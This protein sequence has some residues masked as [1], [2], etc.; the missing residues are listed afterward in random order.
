MKMLVR[1]VATFPMFII[2]ITGQEPAL[3][4]KYSPTPTN[5]S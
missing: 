4:F 1:Q 2:Y 5:S 3:S